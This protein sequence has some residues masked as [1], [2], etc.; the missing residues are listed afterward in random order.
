M[1]VT[2]RH[3]TDEEIN[4]YREHGVVC[5]RQALSAE[6]V[7]VLR[8]TID[9]LER[10]WKARRASITDFPAVLTSAPESL[11]L[12][13]QRGSPPP[14]VLSMNKV[15]SENILVETGGEKNDGEFIVAAYLLDDPEYP[16]VRRLAFESPL[17]TLMGE[18]FGSSKV[19]FGMDQE[20]IKE[21]GAIR[22]T[23]FHQDEG[24]F[25]V[26]GEHCA[27]AWMACEAVDASNGRMGY[28]RGSQRWTTYAPNSFVSQDMGF[29]PS[30]FPRLPDIE[31]HEDDYD[32]VYY[33]VEPGDVIV[34]HYRTVHG[35][36]GNTTA[37]R[38]RCALSI[39]YTG[40]D[41]RYVPRSPAY[42]MPPGL[43]EGDPLDSETFPIVWRAS[44]G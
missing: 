44:G 16:G 42:P 24:Y 14:T 6:W 34:H 18:L 19:N 17:A 10:N 40:D 5:L 9:A 36:R 20:F 11:S 31:G 37:T 23:A 29:V 8:E 41:A 35:A 1:T 15:E 12:A 27:S 13:A 21:P 38:G 25:N 30:D 39:R 2:M 7:A 32:I 3:A 22:R 26:T 33:D 28:V 4:S 43:S